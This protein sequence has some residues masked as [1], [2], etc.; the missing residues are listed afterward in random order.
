MADHPLRQLRLKVTLEWDSESRQFVTFV[1]D[2][3][4]ISTFGPT[5][6]AA[7]DATA[8]MLLGYIEVA[9]QEGIALPLSKSEVSEIR[10]ALAGR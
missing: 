5:E 6:E 8:D 10:A 1:P 4:N 3:G 7:L 9:E 2:L